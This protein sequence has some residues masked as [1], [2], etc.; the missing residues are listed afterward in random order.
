MTVTD[1]QVREAWS[2]AV[3]LLYECG[4]PTPTVSEDFVITAVLRLL[5]TISELRDS[6]HIL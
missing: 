4:Q 2:D 1:D 5:T 6:G 3:C